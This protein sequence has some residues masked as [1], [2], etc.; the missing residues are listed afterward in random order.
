MKVR[1]W[2]QNEK[3]LSERNKN[4]E[5]MNGSEMETT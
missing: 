5:G 3:K 4:S 2:L 1:K